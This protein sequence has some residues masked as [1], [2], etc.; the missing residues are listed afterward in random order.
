MLFWIK[1]LPARTF[2]FFLSVAMFVIVVMEISLFGGYWGLW[3][4]SFIGCFIEHPCEH[5]DYMEVSGRLYWF[6]KTIS[7]HREIWSEPCIALLESH[8]DTI[9]TRVIHSLLLLWSAMLPCKQSLR[10]MGWV[11][12]EKRKALPL[13]LKA[14]FTK[15]TIPYQ[16]FP[17]KVQISEC[18][19]HF[20][21]CGCNREASSWG[22]STNFA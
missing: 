17:L 20:S 1:S 16:Y 5:E 13:S 22:W 6:K 4:V 18:G 10:S 3:S 8:G 15:W 9:E 14:G 21:E 12:I 19:Y 2:A 11:H 7:V